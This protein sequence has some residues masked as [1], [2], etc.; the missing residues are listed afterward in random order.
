MTAFVPDLPATSAR[1]GD[2]FVPE[3]LVAALDELT[4]AF[5]AAQ[6]DPTSP[7]SCPRC[8]ATTPATL[9][10]HRG[11]ALRRARRRCPHP[12]QA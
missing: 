12:A 1:T 8:C 6:A 5:A 2:G 3:A 9:A 11:A 4:E 7:P 10:H